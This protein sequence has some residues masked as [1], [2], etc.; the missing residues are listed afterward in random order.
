VIR[1]PSALDSDTRRAVRLAPPQ[2]QIHRHLRGGLAR[3]ARMNP[4]SECR[5]PNHDTTI[6]LHGNHQ[7]RVII[8]RGGAT[9]DE[10][11]SVEKPLTTEGTAKEEADE[12]AQED[13]EDEEEE[14]AQISDPH[15]PPPL[16]WRREVVLRRSG[17][18]GADVYYHAPCG[19]KM[20]SRPDVLRFLHRKKHEGN[21]QHLGTTVQEFDFS[22]PVI[23]TMAS[24]VASHTDYNL[25]G[26]WVYLAK[27]TCSKGGSAR[28]A[29][30]TAIAI[31]AAATTPAEQGESLSPFERE[32]AERI[33]RNKER[34]AALN[35]GSLAAGLMGGRAAGGERGG[36]GDKKRR[37][38]FEDGPVRRSL[39]RMQITPDA[40]LANSV[41]LERRDGNVTLAPNELG[42]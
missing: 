30:T 21:D 2:R 25:A 6:K 22:K 26:S 41:D 3:P 28:A 42:Q 40:A 24:A 29:A 36:G 14:E 16:G 4:T 5:R 39:R 13:D 35:I 27:Q 34:L 37:V 31:A 9:A 17:T 32:R 38:K 1:R 33:V 19:E 20:R 7:F 12:E 10:P 8:H 18:G 11:A 15:T 23:K